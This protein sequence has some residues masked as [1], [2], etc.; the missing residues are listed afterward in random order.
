MVSGVDIQRHPKYNKGLAF[1]EQERENLYL[2]GLLP[3]AVLSQEL[4]VLL[5][6]PYTR[7]QDPTLM[8]L[9]LGRV[10]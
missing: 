4:Q 6:L 8:H 2:Q 10:D 1:S 7:P 9:R 3:P 5:A